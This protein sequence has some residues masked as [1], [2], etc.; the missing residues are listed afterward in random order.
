MDPKYEKSITGNRSGKQGSLSGYCPHVQRGR[1]KRKHDREVKDTRPNGNSSTLEF[2]MQRTY[3][4]PKITNDML[5][6]IV[7]S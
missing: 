6:T 3:E 1:E 2:L 5:E 7:Y 4:C